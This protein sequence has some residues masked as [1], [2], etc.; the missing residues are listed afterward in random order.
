M[1]APRLAVALALFLLVPGPAGAAEGHGGTWLGLPVWV[2]LWLNFFLFW[3]LLIRLLRPPL[4][5]FFTERR[6]AISS[7]MQDAQRQR[8]EAE[9]L[10][11]SLSQK[12]DAIR[13]EI[14]ELDTRARAEG[15]R[16]RREIVE[17]ARL[18][19]DRLLERT[20]EEL[21]R[22]VQLARADLTRHT[23]KLATRLA[24]E[25]LATE[26]DADGRRRLFDESLERLERAGS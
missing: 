8:R 2:W 1:R 19:Q 5:R 4:E 26:I 17:Q 3:G 25:R 11:S 14:D 22:G 6:N 23:A 15:E 21:A 10:R 20:R 16:E 9:D 12:I 18:E 24:E 7:S 13:R